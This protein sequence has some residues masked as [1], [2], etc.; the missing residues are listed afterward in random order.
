MITVFQYI[1][2]YKNVYYLLNFYMVANSLWERATNMKEE[3][4]QEVKLPMQKNT[5]VQ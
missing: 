2:Y 4:Q 3:T 1:H 5:Y